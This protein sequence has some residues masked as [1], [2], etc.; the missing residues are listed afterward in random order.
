MF[1]GILNVCNWK[2]NVAEPPKP[3]QSVRFSDP[4]GCATSSCGRVK[5]F[6]WSPN[7]KHGLWSHVIFPM[8]LLLGCFSK[9]SLGMK[10]ITALCFSIRP[11]QTNRKTYR[12]LC[13]ILSP[14]FLQLF[15]TT[16]VTETGPMDRNIPFCLSSGGWFVFQTIF[17][18]S[19][20]F[21]FPSCHLVLGFFRSV[22]TGIA[23]LLIR[24]QGPL[25]EMHFNNKGIYH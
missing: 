10:A 23:P 15:Y 4:L 22:H 18:R 13:L 8:H 14:P 17:M 9:A 1:I 6:W 16:E 11:L 19:H 5:Y 24:S 21:H 3:P 20:Y 25:K 7:R 12:L 2:K